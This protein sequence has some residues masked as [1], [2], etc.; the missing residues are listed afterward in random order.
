MNDSR[1]TQVRT[2]PDS[3]HSEPT[4]R[5]ITVAEAGERRVIELIRTLVPPNASWVH[6]GIGDDAAVI[7]PERNTLDVVTT[8]ALVEGVHFEWAFM[9]A[10]DIGHKALAVNLSDLA[11]MGAHPRA[12]LL[13]LALPPHLALDELESLARS[14]LELAREHGVALI[15]GNVT[16]SPGPLVID[17]TAIG[18][19][20]RR[21]VLRRSGARA[22]DQLYVT[23]TLGAAAAGLAWLRG[24]RAEIAEAATESVEDCVARFRRPKPRVRSGVLAGQLRAAS[25][26]IDLS[27]GLA[28]GVTQIAAA[29]GVGARIDASA[30]PIHPGV[31]AVTASDERA[32]H[33]ALTGGEDYELLFAVPKKARRR[34]ADVAR[35]SRGLA[36]TR[37]GEMTKDEALVL[38]T[39]SGSEPLPAGFEHFAVS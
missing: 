5:S 13:S 32:R 15:G 10:A 18:A 3:T 30:L 20:R 2:A 4:P 7:E 33:A 35:L 9:S 22:G 16:A 1:Y 8:D 14:L 25:A 38:E 37:I 12:A 34:F 39:S 21:R 23:G 24:H 26:C 36:F 17:V 19:V 28:D 6:C 27:D 29:S 31:A 11:A